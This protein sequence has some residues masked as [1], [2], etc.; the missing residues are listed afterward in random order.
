ML[1]WAERVVQV[2]FKAGRFDIW[3]WLHYDEPGDIAFCHVC[4]KAEEE[5]KLKATPKTWLS[6]NEGFPTG[7]TTERF[8]CHEQSKC[9]QDAVLV[10]VILPRSC[11]DIGEPL[12]TAHTKQKA[13]SRRVFLKILHNEKFLARQ[14]IALCGH[15]DAESNFMHLFKL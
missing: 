7:K 12:S 6:Y 11:A 8:R 1:I 4:V 2:A 10:M 5:G 14:G 9:H 13:E 3:N 15:N